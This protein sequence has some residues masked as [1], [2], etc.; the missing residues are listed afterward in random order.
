MHERIFESIGI[1]LKFNKNHVVLAN[2]YRSPTPPTGITNSAAY[3]DF[4]ECLQNFLGTISEMG[5]TAYVFSDTNINLLKLLNDNQASNYLN[6]TLF[7]GFIQIIQRATRVQGQSYGLIDH[8]LTNRTDAVIKSGVIV[9]DISDH[10]P[11]FVV[12]THYDTRKR[13]EYFYCRNFTLPNLNNFKQSLAQVNWNSTVTNKNDVNLAYDNFWKIFH[14]LYERHFPLKKTKRN[15]NYHSINNFMTQ[16]LL[17]SRR[18]KNNLHKQSLEQPTPF[19]INYYKTYRNIY[20]SLVRKSRIL[21]YHDSLINSK[22]KP[23]KTWEVIK[24]ALKTS[25]ANDSIPDI[26]TNDGILHDNVDKANA[27]N[28][29]F[30]NIGKD[31]NRSVPCTKAKYTDYYNDSD[32][33]PTLSM[34]DV[35][36]IYVIDIIKSLPN[37]AS[38][39]L[40]GVS[41]KLVK[42]V[43]HELSTP[44]SHIFT[45]SINTGVFPDALKCTRT[46]PV[47]KSGPKN[48]CDNYR[49][50]SLVPTFSKILEKIVATKLSNHLDIKKLI[51]KHQ[52]GFQRNKQ[53]E[54]NLTHLLSFVSN[55]INNNEYCMGIFLDV[56]KAFDCVPHNILFNKLEKMG[57]RGNML[58]W[59]RSYLAKRTQKCDV[60]GS[61]SDEG[62]I[63]IG[64][65]QG[66]TLGPIL[67]L[68]YV[69]D[70]PNSTDMI[71][72]LFADDTACLISDT[73]ITRLYDKANLELQKLACWFKANKLS[74]NVKKTKYIVFHTK[75]KTFD[76][77]DNVLTYND[78]DIGHDD[79]SKKTVLD[80]ICTE[81][82]NI[83]DRTYKYLGIL[84]DEHLSFDQHTT[85]LSG[86]LAKSCYMLSKVKN[87]FPKKTLKV[88]YF[89]LVQSHLLYCANIISCTNAKNIKKIE[90]LQKKAIRLV[91]NV[92]STAH[93]KPLFSEL[94]I[95]PFKDIISLQCGQ[96]MHSVYYGYAPPS[97][98]DI[99]I[100]CPEI[101][102]HNLRSINCFNIPR[103]KTD[104]YKNMPP[105][106]FTS[107]WN[108]LDE[109]KLYRN[110]VTFK[111]ALKD[112]LLLKLSEVTQ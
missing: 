20:N 100:K 37:K 85:Y 82:P 30:T 89:A 64:V 110:P 102:E 106:K 111:H 41:L 108:S 55:S 72:L 27:F 14:D 17:T 75:R 31:I 83:E 54:H 76:P 105:F 23:K 92:N 84:L 49:P 104:W 35:G 34:D 59:F 52:Y 70:L 36:P 57:I 67:F 51:Y 40:S 4:S 9:S 73:N 62:E 50:I 78:N 16:G 39:D 77:A 101:R 47:Y 19:I 88:L 66:S 2:Y 95:L 10:F 112:S 25:K 107:H 60:N 45:L 1:E 53:T 12:D 6:S 18:T 38:K 63:D 58:N 26:L 97:L 87:I 5:K 71:S 90:T 86:K 98:N 91:C 29:F 61:L 44:L 42:F 81:N 24:D 68:C 15:K 80:R 103:P 21:Y 99:F 109:A 46:V 8:I 65:L 22:K 11:I 33:V 74:V 94:S 7:S 69:N 79:D 48:L 96:L 56:K 32:D 93:T 43:K 13:D 28:K 3:D